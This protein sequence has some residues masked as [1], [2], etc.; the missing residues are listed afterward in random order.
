[1]PEFDEKQVITLTNQLVKA[2]PGFTALTVPLDK[3]E[4]EQKAGLAQAF[5]IKGF[6]DYL[7]AQIRTASIHSIDAENMEGLWASKFGI[8]KLK[9]LYRAAQTCHN[10]YEKLSVALKGKGN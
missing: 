6:R 2:L 1:M 10:E 3:N 5:A 7:L 4:A 8:L 9:E